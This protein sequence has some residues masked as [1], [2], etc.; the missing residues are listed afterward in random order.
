LKYILISGIT[1]IFVLSTFE[2]EIYKF[3]SNKKIETING[4]KVIS[5]LEDGMIVEKKFIRIDVIP[6]YYIECKEGF[7]VSFRYRRCMP[8]HYI[9][10]YEKYL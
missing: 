7:A 4:I 10:K 5:I 9:D 3:F 1:L 8:L 2:K 6:N